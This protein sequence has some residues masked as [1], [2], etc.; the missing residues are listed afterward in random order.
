MTPPTPGDSPWP[1]DQGRA[2]VACGNWMLAPAS[3]SLVLHTLALSYSDLST[4]PPAQPGVDLTTV[5]S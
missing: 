2:D 1:L 3:L 4:E 5:F